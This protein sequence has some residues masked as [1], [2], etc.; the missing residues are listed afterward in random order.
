M[1]P[2]LAKQGKYEVYATLYIRDQY[3]FAT[4]SLVYLKLLQGNQLRRYMMHSIRLTR[5]ASSMISCNK[6]A[7][8]SQINQKTVDR[9]LRT[10]TLP[11]SALC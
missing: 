4:L 7:K 5:H 3:P 8:A 10:R 1:W 9:I 2:N 11:F 6:Y